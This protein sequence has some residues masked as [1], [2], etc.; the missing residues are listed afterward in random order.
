MTNP[1]PDD[2]LLWARKKLADQWRDQDDVI[3]SEYRAGNM[4][5][6]CEE[7]CDL[8]DGFRA[9]QSHAAGLLAALEGLH[10]RIEDAWPELRNL[11]PMIAA[12]AAIAAAK[13]A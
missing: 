1:T 4:D 12:R 10:N 7:L 2:A 9:G 13:G 6:N 3:A 11:P 8:A 5:N